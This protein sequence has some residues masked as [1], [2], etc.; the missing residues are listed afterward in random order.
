MGNHCSCFSSSNTTSDLRNHYKTKEI[1]RDSNNMIETKSNKS[2]GSIHNNP[3][4]F[5]N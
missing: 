2:N 1:R 5:K 4:I 3:N